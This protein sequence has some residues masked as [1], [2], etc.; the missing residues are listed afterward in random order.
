MNFLTP[1]PAEVPVIDIKIMV[2]FPDAMTFFVSL[3]EHSQRIR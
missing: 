2:P 1:E 3:K